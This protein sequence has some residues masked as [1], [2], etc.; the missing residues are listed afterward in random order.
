MPRRSQ[1]LESTGLQ[2]LVDVDQAA[3]GQRGRASRTTGGDP[4]SPS[5]RSRDVDETRQS[6]REERER[7]RLEKVS[8]FREQRRR[9]QTAGTAKRFTRLG[10]FTQRRGLLQPSLGAAR[11]PFEALGTL[12]LG[13]PFSPI[14][15][16]ISR[17]LSLFRFVER[18]PAAAPIAI[19]GAM[20]AFIADQTRR[21]FQKD[22]EER[23]AKMQASNRATISQVNLKIDRIVEIL[24]TEFDEKLEERRT[25]EA[26]TDQADRV[27]SVLQGIRYGD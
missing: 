8:K 2:I 26:A 19:T 20:I 25:F 3:R 16:E 15:T 10:R 27:E 11:E 7:K 14:L 24:R 17:P 4:I 13:A 23:I 6:E 22:M 12:G 18:V 21:Q 5:T 1:G 9:Q